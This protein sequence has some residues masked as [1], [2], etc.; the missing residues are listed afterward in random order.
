MEEVF[1]SFNYMGIINRTLVVN[2]NT[3]YLLPIGEIFD[4]LL[5][6]YSIDKDD[7]IIKGFYIYPENEYE[8]DLKELTFKSSTL[9]FTFSKN[10]YLKKE[11]EYYFSTGFFNNAFKLSFSVDVSNLKLNLISDIILPVYSKYL[12]DERY[13]YFTKDKDLDRYPLLYPIERSFFKGGFMDYSLTASYTKQQNT[14]YNYRMGLGLQLFGGDLET[15]FNGYTNENITFNSDFNYRWRYVL[16]KNKFLTQVLV[17]N[18]LGT[19]INSQT[20]YGLQISNRPFEQRETF[21]KFLISDQTL[22][23]STIELYLNNQFIDHTA[24]DAA[25]NFHFWIPLAY[26]SSFI[27]FKFYGPNGEIKIVDKYYQIPYSLN[28]PGEFNYTVD[29]GKIENSKTKYVNASGIY[30]IN[31]WLSNTLGTEYYEDNLF[32]DPIIYNSLTCR[33]SSSYLINIFTAPKAYYR[34]SASAIYPSLTS[35]NFSYTNYESHLLYNPTNI[36]QDITT[37]FNLPLYLDDTPLNVQLNSEYQD[38]PSSKV[39]GLRIGLSKNISSLTPTLVYSFRQFKSDKFLFNNNNFSA[40]IIYSIGNLPWNINFFNG[41]L[42]YSGTTYDLALKKF[43]SYFISLA[44][45]L[46]N[47][48]R[49]QFDYE[50]NLSINTTNARMQIFLEL[51]FTRSYSVVGKDYF[52]SN[53]RGSLIFNDSQNQINFFNRE[54]VGR[55]ASTFRMFI[56]EN[57]NG[58]YDNEEQTI[59][60]ENINIESFGSNFRVGNDKTNIND[61]NPYSVYNVKIDETTLIDPL[62]TPKDKLFSFEANP[63][64]VKNIDIPFYGSNEVNGSVKQISGNISSDAAG[65][66]I[67]IEGIDNDQNIMVSTFSDGSFYY[68]GLRSGKFKIYVNKNQL[69]YLKCISE[70][71]E[72]VLEIE[73]SGSGNSFENLNFEL[74]SK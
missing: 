16:D 69:E 72:R 62:L 54:Q 11:F 50:K 1:L 43:D 67:H 9:K 41:L 48:I 33:L 17:G 73:V 45:N 6:N 44:A 22:P 25:G 23:G 74:H 32:N 13:K 4:L 28:P 36:K 35:I 27:S 60:P 51:P 24:T 42:L 63:N 19:G 12:R 49:L 29:F 26:G 7:D 68:F 37:A 46:T 57:A 59:T 8:I 21:E 3:N 71:L 47:S 15:S 55:A 66:K 38:F 56:D 5:I 64:S 31:D 18:L 58:D 20:H 65:I 61:L 70:P 34:L 14:I 2:Y 10:D 39:Y 40:G 30:G 53:I 52:T